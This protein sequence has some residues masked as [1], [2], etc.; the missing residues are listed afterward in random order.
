MDKKK[1]IQSMMEQLEHDRQ[2][3][4]E[5]TKATLEAAT[6]EESKPEN[7]YDTRGL[8]ASYLAG[9]QSKRVAEIEE[10]LMVCKNIQLRSFTENNP[11]GPT[12]LV[13]LDLDGK[14]SWVFL[15]PK[16]G[17]MSVKL[18]GKT[19]QVVSGQSPLGQALSGLKVGAIAVVETGPN[20]RE[21]EI[22]S[23]E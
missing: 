2:A 1:I 17:G 22:V 16:G 23:V 13:E 14:T 18:E 10:A 20:T 8:E 7:E 9:A 12:A 3:L 6:H 4:L 21:Y 15:M 11:L 5:A 19:I